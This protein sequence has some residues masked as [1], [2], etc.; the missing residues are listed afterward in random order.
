MKANCCAYQDNLWE[1][2]ASSLGLSCTV[3]MAF[4]EEMGSR[5]RENS[6]I[7]LKCIFLRGKGCKFSKLSRIIFKFQEPLV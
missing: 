3:V 7:T 1:D 5:L 4:G 2:G 6:T